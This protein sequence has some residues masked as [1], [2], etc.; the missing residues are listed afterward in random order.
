MLKDFKA[1]LVSPAS[2]VRLVLWVPEVQLVHLESPVK[3]VPQANL[4]D[5]VR[6]AQLELRVLVVSL[7][8]L[9]SLASKESGAT[10]V[11]MVSR[12]ARVLQA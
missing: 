3:M 4:A 10:A 11:L 1:L 12:G 5:L 2:L 7:G 6:E 9:D 8:P